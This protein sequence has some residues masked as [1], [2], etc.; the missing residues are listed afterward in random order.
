[1]CGCGLLLDWF[2]S[3]IFCW[4]TKLFV[5]IKRENDESYFPA[6]SLENVPSASK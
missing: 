1:M 6:I 2:L 5:L 4:A 3:D